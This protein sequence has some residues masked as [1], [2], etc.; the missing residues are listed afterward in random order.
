M[1][2]VT[3]RN[4]EDEWVE[5]AKAEA[6]ARKVS[7]NSVLKEAIAR[8]LGVKKVKASNGLEKFAGCMPFESDEERKQWDEHLADCGQI[9]TEEWK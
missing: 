1:T 2:Q 9:E 8:G 6:V 5:M 4:I 7:M 3:V